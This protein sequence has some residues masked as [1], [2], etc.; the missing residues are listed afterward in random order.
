MIL[1]V[2][3]SALALLVNPSGEPP[4]DQSGVPVS[5]AR[6]RIE[7]LLASLNASDTIIVPTPVL[8]EMLVI[9]GD[10]APAVLEQLTSQARLRIEPFDIRA[11]VETAMMTRA[12]KDAGDKRGGSSAPYQKVKIDRQIVAIARVHRTTRLYADDRNLITFAK[13]LDM[14]VV[15]TWELP[16]PE[17]EETLFSAAGV[18]IDRKPP[19]AL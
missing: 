17:A 3:S 4:T 12:A 14:D 10:G 5:N 13:A 1:T 9:A 6:E 2:D 19:V 18:E 11:A 7:H 15:S 16:L 8:A